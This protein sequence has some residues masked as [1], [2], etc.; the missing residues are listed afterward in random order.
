MRVSAYIGTYGRWSGGVLVPPESCGLFLKLASSSPSNES[1]VRS[2]FPIHTFFSATL[3]RPAASGR[4]C[5]LLCCQRNPVM[6]S[7]I[8]TVL[9]ISTTPNRCISTRISCETERLLTLFLFNFCHN[10]FF[11]TRPTP[12]C[13][14]GHDGLSQLSTFQMQLGINVHNSMPRT[15]N[16]S[17]HFGRMHWVWCSKSFAYL[18]I[19]PWLPPPTRLTFAAS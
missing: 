8:A 13:L 18:A 1:S 10:A 5:F 7:T 6:P 11:L 15:A 16:P 12:V 19:L 4:L 2:T 3:P 14:R 9:C 17:D